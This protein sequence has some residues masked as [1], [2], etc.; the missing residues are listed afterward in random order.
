MGQGEQ[1]CAVTLALVPL[2][3]PAGQG[4]HREVPLA[5]A[6]VPKLQG[7]QAEEPV[8]EVK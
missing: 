1:S 7:V 3:L 4:V 2:Y 8:T 5:G 6:Y